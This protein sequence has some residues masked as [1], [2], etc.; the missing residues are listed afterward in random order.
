MNCPSDGTTLLMSERQGVEVDYC[1]QCRGIWL[2]RGELD[3]I[4]E[5][6]QAESDAAPGSQYAEPRYDD[7]EAPRYDDRR[8][9]SH[10]DDR[11]REGHHGDRRGGYSDD[12]QRDPRYR[13]K[14]SP[15]E[16]L[17]DIFDS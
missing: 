3:K 7:Y 11:R 10:H 6:M 16:F 15:F 14:K 2:D 12:R 17:G 8:R 13:K 5:R 4:L 1:P 9:D